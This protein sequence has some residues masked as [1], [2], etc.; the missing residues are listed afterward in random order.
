M[1]K[2]SGSPL[3]FAFLV[4]PRGLSDVV[5]TY[6]DLKGCEEDVV[7][8]KIQATNVHVIAPMEVRSN[9]V[10]L[11]GELI[12]IPYF[13][14]ELI[15]DPAKG[16]AAIVDAIAYCA[17]RKARIVGLGALLPSITS[18][19]RFLVKQ[20]IDGVGITTGHAYTA[21]AIAEHIDEAKRRVGDMSAPVAVLG[22]AGSTG[23]AAV[24][25][26]ARR[27]EK[28]LI[29]V[30][31]PERRQVLEKQAKS[32]SARTSIET[33][34]SA[35]RDARFLVCATNAI[36]SLVKPD[37]LSESCI[38]VDDAQPENISRDVIDQRPDVTV[39]KCLAHVP[40]LHCSF[41]MGLFPSGTVMEKQEFTFTCL[42]ETILLAA[43]GHSG[44]F[45]VGKPSDEQ[46]EYLEVLAQRWDVG[47]APFHSFP[48]IGEVEVCL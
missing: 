29:L 2:R 33:N 8:R 12:G 24:R 19:G 17:G 10:K 5:R 35:I 21:L 27:G 32:L 43:A 1:V 18:A 26:L 11:H 23:S 37:L 46:F 14:K 6:P 7:Q 39:I 20:G 13:P 15:C 48:D 30:D 28:N 36:H 31:L 44:H 25:C 42:A 4:H 47:I 40:G 45:T 41:D 34:I 38:V 16:R 22:A 3:D 9:G